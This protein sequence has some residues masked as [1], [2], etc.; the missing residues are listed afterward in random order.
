MS[1]GGSPK[2]GDDC[3][4]ALTK[5]PRTD[6][7]CK[8]T[9]SS[10]FFVQVY[11]HN[12]P[13]R[14]S[15]NPW[16]FIGGQHFNVKISEN[17]GFN[18][19]PPRSGAPGETFTIFP[20]GPTATKCTSREGCGGIVRIGEALEWKCNQLL[21][22]ECD[23]TAADI[24]IVCIHA[25]QLFDAGNNKEQI[26]RAMFSVGGDDDIT[27]PCWKLGSMEKNELV[28]WKRY[29]EENSKQ[30]LQQKLDFQAEKQQMQA[31]HNAVQQQMQA[32]KDAMQEKLQL[33]KNAIE[34]IR[35]IAMCPICKDLMSDRKPGML[36]ECGHYIC[37]GC[38]DDYYHGIG[39]YEAPTCSTC[40][41][42][43]GPKDNWKKFFCMTGV[44]AALKQT[45]TF[46][47]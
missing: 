38:H 37:A 3:S 18:I 47:D 24:M 15:T 45:V 7:L 11:L 16:Q 31:A 35:E 43:V 27:E 20:Y 34:A 21:H 13:W 28:M 5:R 42:P 33:Y 36:S 8:Q 39:I 10:G 32:A 22:Y 1:K 4:T 40:A 44:V 30:T 12:K 6:S 29:S 14:S 26:V 25:Q 23:R 19:V 46:H 41:L 17:M 9:T 2:Q